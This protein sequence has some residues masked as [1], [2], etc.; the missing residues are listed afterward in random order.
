MVAKR[1][2]TTKRAAPQPVNATVFGASWCPYTQPMVDKLKR[3]M[4]VR[5]VDCDKKMNTVG[6]RRTCARLTRY[7][8]VKYSKR[9]A[10]AVKG[11]K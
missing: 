3:R 6:D 1:T 10:V 8:T 5:Y 9:S 11:G 7:P 2:S 4:P